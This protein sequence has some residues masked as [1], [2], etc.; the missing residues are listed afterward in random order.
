MIKTAFCCMASDG[1][2]DDR[3]ISIIK[4]MCAN[5]PLFNNFNF[6][7]EINNLIVKI[8]KDGI[9]F[10]SYYFDLIS[11]TSLTEKEE[12]MLIDF[13][14]NTI[15]ADGII[16]YSEIRF[17]KNIRNRLSLSN[18]TILTFL[19]DIED[20]LESDLVSLKTLD[21]FPTDYLNSTVLPKFDFIIDSDINNDQ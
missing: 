5:T 3:E 8:N 4:T 17:F 1:H 20:F 19:P 16:E 9:N 21:K 10:L 7:E 13:A 12:L 6:E 18:D 15:K 11:N 2:I 14:I